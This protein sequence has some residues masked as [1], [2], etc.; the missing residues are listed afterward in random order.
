MVFGS[1][2]RSLCRLNKLGVY[3]T[4]DKQ[5]AILRGDTSNAVVN[6]NFID[7]L[8]V[9]GP[10]L[11]GTPEGTPAMIQI[12]ARYAQRAWESLIELNRTDRE[13]EK[14]QALVL[15]AHV[16]IFI[17]M[18]TPAQLYLLKACKI[19]EKEKLQFLPEYGSPPKL[20]DQ[21]R[22]DASVLSQLIYL[23]NYF[24]LMLG[25]AVPAKTSRIE[26]EFKFELQV[27]S[28]R[29][30]FIVGFEIDP[31]IGVASVPTPLRDMPA[32][33]ANSKHSVGQRRNLDPELPWP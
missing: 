27:R 31:A 33:H 6:R 18:T 22:E 26:R 10:H 32:N 17:G 20:S 23:E 8:Q 19:I 21:V 9:M 30:V 29:S 13:R 3:F 25:G 4:P 15:L 14:T 7:A 5:D 1:R 16:F 28:I 12:Q 11:G 2:L 24:Y